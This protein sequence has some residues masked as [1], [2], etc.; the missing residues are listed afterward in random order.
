MLCIGTVDTPYGKATLNA[1]R[2]PKGKSICIQLTSEEGEPFGVLSVNLPEHNNRIERACE[3]FVK[4]WCENAPL[5]EPMLSSKL[6]VDTGRRVETEF[7]SASIWA[8]VAP[9]DIPPG[10]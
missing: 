3:F 1:T 10:K 5:I 8:I 7:V 9:G 4:T 6:F 2:Y